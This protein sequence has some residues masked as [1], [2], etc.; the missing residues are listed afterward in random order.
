MANNRLQLQSKL[1]ELLGSRQV[2]YQSPENVKM[3]YPAIVY[4][5]NAPG[6]RF[7]S[8]KLH[9]NKNRYEVIVISK[10]PDPD[11]VEKILE[12]PY[13]SSGKPYVADNLNHYPITLYF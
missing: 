7:A 11:V 2:Y 9:I 3:Q 5:R 10:K 13:T 8:N 12:L 6:V 1:E 4:S